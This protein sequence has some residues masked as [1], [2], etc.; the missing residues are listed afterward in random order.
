MVLGIIIMIKNYHAITP[1]S[2]IIFVHMMTYLYKLFLAIY[3]LL[4]LSLVARSSLWKM[5]KMSWRWTFRKVICLG[6]VAWIVPSWRECHK[7]FWGYTATFPPMS[8]EL[9]SSLVMV[10]RWFCHTWLYWD[11]DLGI[12]Y[13]LFHWLFVV[14]QW[15]AM[16]L[17]GVL[18]WLKGWVVWWK[19]DYM[20]LQIRMKPDVWNSPK[21][22]K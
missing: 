1:L 20:T 9:L 12:G 17:I 22:A 15:H 13:E 16:Y 4:H 10:Q 8:T 14:T 21:N 7:G 18:L 11:V 3:T 6:L 19:N 2:G 5:D